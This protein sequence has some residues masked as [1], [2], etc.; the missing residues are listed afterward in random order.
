MATHEVSI[1]PFPAQER[2]AQTIPFV[3]RI[4]S[5]VD[6]SHLT[7][8]N[9]ADQFCD[10]RELGTIHCLETEEDLCSRHY[11]MRL[12]EAA[13]PTFAAG[14]KKPAASVGLNGQ[15]RRGFGD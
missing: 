13:S 3:D 9:W 8:C 12:A 14:P 4:L 7:T 11:G 15:A 1:H 5:I 6:R 10:C 2:V